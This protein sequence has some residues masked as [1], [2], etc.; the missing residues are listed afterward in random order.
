[1]G[2][3]LDELVGEVVCHKLTSIGRGKIVSTRM[4]KDEEKYIFVVFDLFPDEVKTYGFPTA[5]TGEV[6][7]LKSDSPIIAEKLKECDYG[8]ICYICGERHRRLIKLG[9]RHI[10]EGCFG[11]MV[12]CCHC[13]T[14]LHPSEA[15]L[16]T[17]DWLS[18]VCY[19]CSDCAQE[20]IVCPQCK[21]RYYFPDRKCDFPK[22]PDTNML[23]PSC[24]DD[25]LVPCDQ[26]HEAYLPESIIAVDGYHICHGCAEG[27]VVSCAECGKTE[28]KAGPCS[29][30]DRE[31]GLCQE[32][33]IRVRYREWGAAMGAYIVSNG[34]A[35][36]K[37][38]FSYFKRVE[39]LTIMNRLSGCKEPHIDFML[40]SLKNCDLVI[41]YENSL[42]EEIKKYISNSRKGNRTMTEFKRSREY[43]WCEVERERTASAL[44]IDQ[45][46]GF[47]LW[48]HPYCLRAQTDRVK[49][50]R[51]EWHGEYLEYEGN[52]YG[53]T[54]NFYI[55]GSLR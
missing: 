7:Y 4:D 8:R 47:Y 16:K 34:S 21:E 29:P 20:Y 18:K 17:K 37:I 55:V 33:S 43:T 3:S 5:F 39:L 22:V 46:S 38:P 54:E 13:G 40:I 31:K 15:V 51:K 25:L 6:P 52:E 28:L 27:N 35:K 1:M 14:R 12:F 32:C 19:V 45:T 49:N 23:C 44:E 2:A 41:V 53:D 24:L 50:Y 10:C 42:P 36:L 30:K 26:C 48:K 11:E 9:D